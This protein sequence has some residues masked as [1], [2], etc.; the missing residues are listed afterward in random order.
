MTLDGSIERLAEENGE[1]VNVVKLRFFVGLSIDDA[2]AALGISAS[3]AKRH[4]LTHEP[5]SL[6]PSART[7][8][9]HRRSNSENLRQSVT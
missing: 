1:C 8:V 2:A 3:T 6:T 7:T 9:G 5:G 4:W